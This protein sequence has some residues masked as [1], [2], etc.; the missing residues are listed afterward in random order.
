M[1]TLLRHHIVLLLLRVVFGGSMIIGHGWPKLLKLM[2]G[3]EIK[4]M[5]FMGL[6]PDISLALVVFSEGLCALLLVLGLFT[7]WATI[8]L[9]FTMLVA[10]LKANWGA[11]FVEWE[12]A[13]L[14][15]S[16]Y[17]CLFITGAG[18]YSIDYSM[19]KVA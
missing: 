11:P 18:R 17:V 6:G 3:G 2:A 1:D 13:L 10:I 12:K 8:P 15:L 16:V 9:I 4:F 14:F 19:Q 5:N 7:R